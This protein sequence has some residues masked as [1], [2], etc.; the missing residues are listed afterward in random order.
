MEKYGWQC[1]TIKYPSN[2]TIDYMFRDS[3]PANIDTQ[4]MRYMPA[5][6]RGSVGNIKDRR[7]VCEKFSFAGNHRVPLNHF[8]KEGGLCLGGHKL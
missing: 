2:Q 8:L 5:R 4:S 6:Y 7:P 1:I 3:K